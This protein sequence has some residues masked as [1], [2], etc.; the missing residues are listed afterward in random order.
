MQLIEAM[1]TQSASVSIPVNWTRP[2]SVIQVGIA[3]AAARSITPEP[4]HGSLMVSGS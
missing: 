4:T 3:A 1:R 2:S